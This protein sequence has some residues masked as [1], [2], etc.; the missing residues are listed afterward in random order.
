MMYEQIKKKEFIHSEFDF[1]GAQNKSVILL[2][3]LL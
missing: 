2:L 3:R 1:T